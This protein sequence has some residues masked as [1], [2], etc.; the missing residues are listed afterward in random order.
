[1]L[2]VRTCNPF[3]EDDK[4][5]RVMIES[6][7]QF[8]GSPGA[9]FAAACMRRFCRPSLFRV[10]AFQLLTGKGR[11]GIM[12]ELG[13]VASSGGRLYTGSYVTVGGQPEGLLPSQAASFNLGVAKAVADVHDGWKKTGVR[14][15]VRRLADALLWNEIPGVGR[16]MAWQHALDMQY[17]PKKEAAVDNGDSPI[18]GPGA[19]AGARLLFPAMKTDDAIEY[20]ASASGQG[21]TNDGGDAMRPSAV[22]HWLCEF[23]KLWRASKGGHFERYKE[24][25]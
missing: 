21:P 12:R 4:A 6:L 22:E 8:A 9:A 24:R 11:A 2:S 17:L 18:A 16:F 13:A 20:L 1:M 3:R 25:T 15:T 23:F 14:W 7:R 10:I 19:K 5:S